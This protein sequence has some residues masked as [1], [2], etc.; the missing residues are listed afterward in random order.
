MPERSRDCQGAV[1]IAWGRSLS[2]AALC[3]GVGEWPIFIIGA[4]R[5]P[6]MERSALVVAPGAGSA[7]Y[8][9]CETGVD[10]W[11]CAN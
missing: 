1:D 2:F 6:F 10:F 3:W 5:P 11:E 7:G 8:G 9:R 4:N